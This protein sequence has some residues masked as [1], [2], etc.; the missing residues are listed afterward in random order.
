MKDTDAQTD[1]ISLL[2]GGSVLEHFSV[3]EL[4]NLLHWTARVQR[5]HR[6]NR[7]FECALRI[8][9]MN[10]ARELRQR[11]QAAGSDVGV[12]LEPEQACE[13]WRPKL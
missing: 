8:L 5:T 3:T 1:S 9:T 13:S 2:R 10:I 6:G 11:R 12:P 7:Q 4:E